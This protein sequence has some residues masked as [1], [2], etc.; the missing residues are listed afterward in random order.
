MRVIE[1]DF[2]CVCWGLGMEKKAGLWEDTVHELRGL[3]TEV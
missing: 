3:Q 1:Y 2:M